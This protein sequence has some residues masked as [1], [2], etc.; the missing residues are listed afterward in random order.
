MPKS[1][2]D[3]VIKKPNYTI[4]IKNG[5]VTALQRKAY[6]VLL[7]YAAKELKLDNTKTRFYIPISKIKKD[8]GITTTNNV[9]LKDH[10]RELMTI[11]VECIEKNNDWAIFCLLSQ[12]V[13]ESN[14]L[15]YEFPSMI[16]DE[17][18]HNNYYTTLNLVTMKRLYG[19]YA[20]ILYELAIRYKNVQIP[21]YSIDGIDGFKEI[22]GTEEYNNFYDLERRVIVPAI[23]EINEKTDITMSYH[24]TKEG[25]KV[26]EIK[27]NFKYKSNQ[28]I[29]ALGIFINEDNNNKQLLLSDLTKTIDTS[30]EIA[31]STP[32]E[33]HSTF[34]P[35]TH[36][37]TSNTQNLT[38]NSEE[39]T[40]LISL[41]PAELQL[42]SSVI[43]AIKTS[44]T[45]HGYDYVKSNI[46]YTLTNSNKNK[47]AFLLKSLL[48]DWGQELRA[49]DEVKKKATM[50]K[51]IEKEEENIK[52]EE[53]K[54][55]YTEKSQAILKYYN[56]LPNEK[57]EEIKNKIN[58]HPILSISAKYRSNEEM[59][60]TYF[61]LEEE[62]IA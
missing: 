4:T 6:N 10:L 41:L 11:T 8:A 40:N 59:I 25:R 54:K 19:K 30:D 61:N 53:E 28:E 37:L 33:A 26:T 13:K 7:C 20:I 50:H 57:K 9:Y 1:K 2:K 36:S 15:R 46:K 51:T 60:I 42:Q 45:E 24:L 18:I 58:S 56:S 39:L 48:S 47:K 5:R 16:I 31:H 14:L 12:A 35:E 43:K 32:L 23:Q 22:T 38:P 27:F 21:K 17:L 49:K 52:K 44:L 29:T 34:L 3:L 62:P 55:A